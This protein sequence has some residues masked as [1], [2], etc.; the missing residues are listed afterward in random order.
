MPGEWVWVN[1][2]LILLEFQTGEEKAWLFAIYQNFNFLIFS[3]EEIFQRNSTYSSA[4]H[5]LSAT[6][7]FL[8]LFLV[9]FSFEGSYDVY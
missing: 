6:L 1:R 2:A 7:I 4:R 5:K 8:I 9:I 3:L